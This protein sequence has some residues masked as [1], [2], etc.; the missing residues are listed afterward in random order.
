V[1][2]VYVPTYDWEH[3][4]TGIS[5]RTTLVHNDIGVSGIHDAEYPYTLIGGEIAGELLVG[6]WGEYAFIQDSIDD[7]SKFTVGLDYSFPLRLY[8]MCEYFFDGSGVNDPARYEYSLVLTGERQTLAQHYLYGSI[9]TIPLPFDVFRPSISA[10]V[11]LDDQGVV[12][13]PQIAVMP[14][15]NADIAVGSNIV[16]GADE[17]EFRNLTPFNGAMYIWLKVYF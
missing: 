5:V 8:A 12:L 16:I 7:F 17:C 9:S 14:F 1:R 11:N 15:D 6:Y 10:L 2:G 4:I 13:I 3:S